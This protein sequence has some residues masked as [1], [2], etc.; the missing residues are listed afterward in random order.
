MSISNSNFS[1][2]T[3]E[4][5]NRQPSLNNFAPLREPPIIQPQIEAPETPDPIFNSRPAYDPIKEL[6]EDRARRNHMLNDL[7]LAHARKRTSLAARYNA[8]PPTDPFGSMVALDYYDDGII[9]QSA[10]HMRSR[11]RKL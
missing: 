1:Y 6:K 5:N 10:P 8:L 7:R 11:Y 4:A 3:P 2:Y 9:N